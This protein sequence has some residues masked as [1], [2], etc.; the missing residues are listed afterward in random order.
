M[1]RAVRATLAAIR[2]YRRSDDRRQRAADASWERLAKRHR[3]DI[4]A[5]AVAG[6]VGEQ[7]AGDAP[8]SRV[9][10]SLIAL[11]VPL[12]LVAGLIAI[13][14]G[15]SELNQRTQ[16]GLPYAVVDPHGVAPTGSANAIVAAGG[17]TDP[18]LTPPAPGASS[19]AG[20]AT[21]A[22]TLAA[23]ATASTPPLGAPV[24]TSP[25]APAGSAAA[26]S[27]A[28]ATTSPSLVDLCRAVVAAGHGWPSVL[29][30]ADRATVIAAAGSKQN[31]L[32]YCTGLV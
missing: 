31:V 1:R 10:R 18:A 11:G 16:P 24:V 3:T 7:A 13:L 9:R 17:K 12:A 28:T 20:T 2:A 19:S 26:S 30:G 5:G 22:G 23:G 25:P 29:K 4:G 14:L 15:V 21:G 6:P 32:N 8:K 27:T